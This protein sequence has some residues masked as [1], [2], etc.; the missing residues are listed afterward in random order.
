V[1][2]QDGTRSKV[3]Y[4]IPLTAGDPTKAVLIVPVDLTT[5]EAERISKI[6]LAIGDLVRHGPF[7]DE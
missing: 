1:T 6:V 5:A 4:N 7:D 3:T 2:R